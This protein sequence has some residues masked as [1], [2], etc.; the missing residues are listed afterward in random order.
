LVRRDAGPV[1]LFSADAWLQ[2]WGGRRTTSTQRRWAENCREAWQQIWSDGPATWGEAVER[3]DRL[4][5]DAPQYLP[6]LEIDAAALAGLK[7]SAETEIA[8]A[9]RASLAAGFTQ[10][11]LALVIHHQT[12]HLTSRLRA[13]GAQHERFDSVLTIAVEPDAAAPPHGISAT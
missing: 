5:T 7:V 8:G 1:S 3:Y 13:G 6:K 11:H 2:P 12:V 10:Q 4:A 9:E